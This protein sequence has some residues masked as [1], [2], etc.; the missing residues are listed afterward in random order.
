MM[1]IV[2]IFFALVMLLL[3][4]DTIIKQLPSCILFAAL[5]AAYIVLAIRQYDTMRSKQYVRK[6]RSSTPSGD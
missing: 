5:S 2:Y 1:L 6:P 3:G 4:I